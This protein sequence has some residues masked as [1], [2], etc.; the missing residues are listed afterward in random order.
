VD[1]E[2]V[3]DQRGNQRDGVRKLRSLGRLIASQQLTQERL[4]L[5]RGGGHE[6]R[7]AAAALVGDDQLRI[8]LMIA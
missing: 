2:E 8:V 3:E 6:D 1:R 4:R 5:F 7:L